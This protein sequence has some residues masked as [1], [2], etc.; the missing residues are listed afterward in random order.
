MTQAA[1]ANEYDPAE[2]LV[3][4]YL[5]LFPSE[6]VEILNAFPLGELAKFLE[7][8][9]PARAAEILEKLSEFVASD[10]LAQLALP[11]WKRIA[12]RLDPYRASLLISRLDFERR[13][14]LLG[15]LEAALS[16]EIR[17]LMS[18]PADTAGSLMDTR[19]LSFRPR[20]TVRDALA[21]LGSW[22]RRDTRHVLVTSAEGKLLGMLPLTD[23]ALAP[24]RQRLEQLLKDPAPQIGAMASSED[25]L[26][27]LAAAG[28]GVLPVVDGQGRLLGVIRQDSIIQAVKEQATDDLATLVGASKD[29]LALSPPLFAVRKRLP[30]LNINLLTAFLAAAVVGLFE[31]TIAQF[32]AL[33][34]LLPVVAGQSGNTGAQALAITI[35]GLALREIR[36]SDFMPVLIKEAIAGTLN[37]IAVA[38]V[39][40]IAVYF[41]SGSLGLCLVI[42]LSMVIAMAIAGVAGAA[43]PLVLAA[44]K[45]DPAQSGSIILTTVTD[46]FGFF[47]FLGLATIFSAI[48]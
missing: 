35:R 32:T 28:V 17:E 33:A 29:E 37:G 43:I 39:T 34:V 21:R 19:L 4:R 8:L 14:V 9:E 25:V 38:I 42:F 12:A 20:D 2:L 48:L 36:S 45:Q 3:K 6:A 47:S 16:A 5:D 1:R 24:P 7:N 31:S 11:A 15:V 41:W 30:W 23:V 22:H 13:E 10:C 27:T 40:S 46:V 18:Y 44:M 26:K